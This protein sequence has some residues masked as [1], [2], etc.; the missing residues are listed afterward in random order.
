MQSIGPRTTNNQKQNDQNAHFCWTLKKQKLVENPCSAGSAT[1]DPIVYCSRQPRSFMGSCHNNNFRLVQ[2]L[3]GVSC[4][5]TNTVYHTAALSRVGGRGTTAVLVYTWYVSGIEISGYGYEC[6]ARLSLDRTRNR[7]KK[8]GCIT[9][10]AQIARDSYYTTRK[11]Y[12][13]MIT[14]RQLTPWEQF[15]SRTPAYTWYLVFI[16]IFVTRKKANPP[17]TQ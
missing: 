15:E 6:T 2:R 7:T 12:C 1:L 8:S 13:R 16:R 9:Q 17:I 10:Q 3:L 5:R 11:K 14:Q 4:G